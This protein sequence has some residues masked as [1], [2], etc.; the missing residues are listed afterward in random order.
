MRDQL[1]Q[2][3]QSL[4][5]ETT[6]M[7]NYIADKS[8]QLDQWKRDAVSKINESFTN[9]MNEIAM[10]KGDIEANKTRDKIAALQDAV[11]QARAVQTQETQFKQGLAQF[12][13]QTLQQNSSRSFTPQEI[14]GVVNDML[15]Q[16]I[17]G[18]QNSTAPGYST[19]YNPNL[20]KSKQDELSGLGNPL[21]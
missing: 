9:S 8:T 10:R 7:K 14:A 11:N 19:L 4:A 15:G 20:L 5:G 12:A 17:S 6:K 3:R 1:E 2:G 13:V 16:N 18:F 21:S